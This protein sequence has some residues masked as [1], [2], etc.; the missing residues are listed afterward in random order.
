MQ[1]DNVSTLKQNLQGKKKKKD[2]KI[3]FILHE[4]ENPSNFNDA[5]LHIENLLQWDFSRFYF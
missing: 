5:Q 4:A 2:S 3:E 1:K